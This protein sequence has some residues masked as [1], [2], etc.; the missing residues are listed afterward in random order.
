M[1]YNNGIRGKVYRQGAPPGTKVCVG[2]EYGHSTASA[3]PP[4]LGH[5]SP[6]IRQR[7]DFVV[8]ILVHK[9][10]PLGYYP[11]WE[12]QN[13]SEGIWYETGKV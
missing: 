10:K 8:R 9:G 1:F 12:N 13:S 4:E 2:G 5:F 6:S 3:A 11:S 7:S